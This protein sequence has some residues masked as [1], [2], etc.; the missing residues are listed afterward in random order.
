MQTFVKLV[1]GPNVSLVE[2]FGWNNIIAM[3][4]SWF[5]AVNAAFF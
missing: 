1:S 3:I 4:F 5:E 2:G